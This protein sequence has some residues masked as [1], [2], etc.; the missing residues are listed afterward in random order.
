MYTHMSTLSDPSP[1]IDRGIALHKIIRFITHTLGGEAYLNFMGNEFGHP[2]WLDF[3]RAGNN[4][5]YHYARRQW[6][7]VDDNNLKYK[8]L[9]AWDAAMNHTESKYGWL[10]A[11]PAYVS[12]KHEG[13]KIIAFERAGLLFVFNFHPVKSFADYRIGIEEPGE[14]RIVLCSDDKEF[15]GFNRI[16]T[17][18]KFFTVPEG[19]SGRRNYVQVINVFIFILMLYDEI[20]IR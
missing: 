9:N 6:H 5:S 3:P 14:Y 15:G 20:D 19:Y 1:I 16:D 17:S 10:S 18:V 7:L 2:E 12:M 11:H 4:S 13:D 8:Y